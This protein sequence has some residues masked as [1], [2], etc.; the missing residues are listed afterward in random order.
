MCAS[1]QQNGQH[2]SPWSPGNCPELREHLP[3]NKTPPKLTSD[4]YDARACDLPSPKTTKCTQTPHDYFMSFVAACENKPRLVCAHTR[5]ST[6]AQ[7]LA[8]LRAKNG[9]EGV[10]NRNAR[11]NPFILITCAVGDGRA[12]HACSLALSCFDVNFV[13]Q[14]HTPRRRPQKNTRTR[15]AR[16][17][18]TRTTSGQVGCPLSSSMAHRHLA[19]IRVHRRI[20][21]VRPNARRPTRTSQAHQ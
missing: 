21:G 2:V 15:V 11:V 9:G 4:R 6:I 16:T 14:H 5:E 12:A 17:F 7:T 3:E 19:G 8:D 1:A 20:S 13:I 10:Q 18:C